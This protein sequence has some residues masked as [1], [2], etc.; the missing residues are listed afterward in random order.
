MINQTNVDNMKDKTK[1]ILKGL[2]IGFF[3][4]IV[5]WLFLIFLVGISEDFASNFGVV[6]FLIFPFC[7]FIKMSGHPPGCQLLSVFVPFIYAVIGAFIGLFMFNRK[8]KKI[9]N[10]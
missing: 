5:I 10:T 2:T 3:L 4:P 9:K 6:L 8:I 1:Y 7:I